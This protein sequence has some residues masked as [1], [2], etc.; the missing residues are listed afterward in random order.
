M[1]ADD[2]IKVLL[3]YI[4]DRRKKKRFVVSKNVRNNN[5]IFF[6][7]VKTNFFR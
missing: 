6:R 2:V 7:F 1:C 3:A 5:A 4:V